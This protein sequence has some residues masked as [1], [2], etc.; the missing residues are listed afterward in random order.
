MNKKQKFQNF[1]ESLKDGKQDGLIESVKKGFQ[2]CFENDE[3]ITYERKKKGENEAS[4]EGFEI[5]IPIHYL[6]TKFP[7]MEKQIS[8]IIFDI[9]DRYGTINDDGEE[10]GVNRDQLLDDLIILIKGDCTLYGRWLGSF[11]SAS[12]DSPADYPYWETKNI[13]F[14]NLYMMF[15]SDKF[16]VEKSINVE[17]ESPEYKWMYG[18]A[19]EYIETYTD[20]NID[21]F[22][23][24]ISPPRGF[25]S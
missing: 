17:T 13:K 4:I 14:D 7:Q 16:N 20:E 2:A 23:E 10:I 19:S 11:V 12:E 24:E 21:D 9:N 6:L 15:Y 3:Q 18:T 1:L 22:I 8:D 25:R 5:K